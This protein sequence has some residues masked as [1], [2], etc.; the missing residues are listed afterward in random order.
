[1]SE[2]TGAVVPAAGQETAPEVTVARNVHGKEYNQ[3]LVGILS[4]STIVMFYVTR[5]PIRALGVWIAFRVS[6]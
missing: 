2:Q 6:S 4:V 1:M 5:P 3:F